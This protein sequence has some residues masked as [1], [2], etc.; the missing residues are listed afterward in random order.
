MIND[1]QRVNIG[2]QLPYHNH[3]GINSPKIPT[4]YVIPAFIFTPTQLTTYL[5]GPANEGDAFS[6]FDGTNYYFYVRINKVWK[7]T[8]LS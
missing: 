7:R 4:K 3:D 6:V 5:A 1:I 2:Q 8:T